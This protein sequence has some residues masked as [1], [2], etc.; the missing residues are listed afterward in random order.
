MQT[1]MTDTVLLEK[2]HNFP[3]E[4]QL[5]VSAYFEVLEKNFYGYK[6]QKTLIEKPKR[7]LG[8]WEGTKFY[9]ASDFN[10]PLS[11]LADYM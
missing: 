2:Y 6:I 8:I 1:I 10:E 4:L 7:K 3:P 5:A 9:I 11:D